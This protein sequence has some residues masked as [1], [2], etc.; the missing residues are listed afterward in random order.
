MTYNR[1]AVQDG[2]IITGELVYKPATKENPPPKA[3]AP[4]ADD[5]T[6]SVRSDE[7]D[8]VLSGEGEMERGGRGSGGAGRSSEA[9]GRSTEGGKAT[10]EW[11]NPRGDGRGG[12]N[13]GYSGEP[14]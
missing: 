1:L 14:Y 3:V 10:G 9:G 7:L 8:S 13:H 11:R 5:D 2:A 4:T 6:S 12:R